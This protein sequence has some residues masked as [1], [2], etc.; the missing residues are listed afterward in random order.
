V[1]KRESLPVDEWLAEAQRLPVGQ[2][3]RVIHGAEGR[4]NMV[5]R[6]EQGHWGA[7]CYECNRRGR[8]MKEHVRLVDTPVQG[9]APSSYPGD[10][11]PIDRSGSRER[12][13][14]V[15]Y[16]YKGVSAIILGSKNSFWS[17]KD[18]RIVFRT[19][20]GMIGRALD[21][22]VLN[23]WHT[24]SRASYI[25]ARPVGIAGRYIILTE[26]YYSAMKLQHY[27]EG[28]FPEVLAVS[29]CGTRVS[30]SLLAQLA[31]AAAVFTMFDGDFW[32]D[33]A[34]DS[35]ERSVSLM[36]TRCYRIPTPRGLDPKDLSALEIVT[37]FQR[38]IGAN[39][40]E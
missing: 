38:A 23:K 6:N 16:Q 13:I 26:D 20:D 31:D 3:K 27:L 37:T 10:L 2:T 22:W 34:A 39:Y 40:V 7:F 5:L 33:K 25:R 32:G 30:P 28:G 19:P 12:D 17:E 9:P 15:H 11:V 18:R 35:A 8:K 36:G 24:Y 4:A 1:L 14:I 29:C 21:P